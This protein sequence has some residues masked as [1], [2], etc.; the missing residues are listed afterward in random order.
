MNGIEIFISVETFREGA[1]HVFSTHLQ[2]I[3][4][5]IEWIGERLGLETKHCDILLFFSSL[6]YSF[7]FEKFEI[8]SRQF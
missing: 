3:Q 5:V 8:Y 1:I 7:N 2:A 4:T 6:S